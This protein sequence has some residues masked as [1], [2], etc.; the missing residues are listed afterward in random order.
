MKWRPESRERRGR[1]IKENAVMGAWAERL[2]EKYMHSGDAGEVVFAGVCESLDG[3][4]EDGNVTV[5][6][7]FFI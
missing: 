3:V 2:S 4:T 1:D 5:L 7:R 6:I